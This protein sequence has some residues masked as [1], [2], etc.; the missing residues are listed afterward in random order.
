MLHRSHYQKYLFT[1]YYIISFFF[2]SDTY[3]W[4]HYPW[5]YVCF[6]NNVNQMWFL[7]IGLDEWSDWTC[8]VEKI[9]LIR[10]VKTIRDCRFLCVSKAYQAKQGNYVVSNIKYRFSMPYYSFNPKILIQPLHVLI[11]KFI[12]LTMRKCSIQWRRSLFNHP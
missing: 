5:Y 1:R 6:C 7:N 10:L 4:R 3:Y 12:K 9:I 2:T 11:K 8:I